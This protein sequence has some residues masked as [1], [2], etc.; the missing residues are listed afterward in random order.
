[1]YRETRIAIQLIVFISLFILAAGAAFI[2]SPLA[3]PIN[4]VNGVITFTMTVIAD[5]SK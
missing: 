1:M 5:R 3:V 4:I 2:G